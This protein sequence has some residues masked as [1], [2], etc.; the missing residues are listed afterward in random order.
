MKKLLHL[1]ALMLTALL[2]QAASGQGVYAD[3]NGDGEVNIADVNEVVNV[4]LD[5]TTPTPPPVDPTNDTIVATVFDTNIAVRHYYRIPA[6]VQLADGKLLAIADDRHNSDTDIG[7]N[8]GIDIVGKI[9]EDNGKTWG[10]TIMIADGNQRRQ[11]FDNSHGDAAA[12]VDRETG[13]L[14]IMCASGKQGFLASTLT[15]P[16]LVGRYTSED[17]TTWTGSEVT[18]DIYGIFAD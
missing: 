16:L 5:G 14:L 12:I 13:K 11:G 17:S 4:I 3:V 9:S 6:I 8:Q 15:N 7:S 10:T 1:T 18:N 2:T